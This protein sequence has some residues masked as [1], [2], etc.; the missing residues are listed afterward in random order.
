MTTPG[1]R[2][3]VVLSGL[4][5][6]ADEHKRAFSEQR[7]VEVEEAKRQASTDAVRRETQKARQAE[8][9]T[10]HRAQK[11]REAADQEKEQKEYQAHE[12]VHL[13]LMSFS[14]QSK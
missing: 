9:E 2:S 8:A 13:I 11:A 12:R 4:E 7:K 3:S 1:K 5:Q 10:K 6:L 14:M